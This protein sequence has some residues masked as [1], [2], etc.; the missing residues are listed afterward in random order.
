MRRTGEGDSSVD[1]VEPH[2]VGESLARH[3][4]CVCGFDDTQKIRVYGAAPLPHPASRAPIERTSSERQTVWMGHLARARQAAEKGPAA[5][6]RPKAAGEAYPWYVE[7]AAEGANEADGHLPRARQAAEKGPAAR[8]RPKAAGEAYPWY[9]EPAA[10]GANEADGPLSTACP[11]AGV[12]LAGALEG[13]PPRRQVEHGGGKEVGEPADHIAHRHDADGPTLVVHEGHGAVA[14]HAHAV[15][16]VGDAIADGEH[17]G[18]GRH[19]H[20]QRGGLWIEA[21]ADHP[22]EE[23][24][25]G[26]DAREPACPVHHEDRGLARVDHALRRLV[27][28]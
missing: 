4:I 21:A 16:G 15:H 28:G 13:I 5:R 14:R 22:R 2:A 1:H 18:L 9:V 3:E 19:H 7:P 23:I 10:E 6:R 24:A 11:L 27:H 25:L 12:D 26:E 17:L 20:R 8:R